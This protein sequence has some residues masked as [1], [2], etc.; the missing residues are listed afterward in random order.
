MFTPASDTWTTVMRTTTTERNVWTQHQNVLTRT[1]KGL[2]KYFTICAPS[3][4]ESFFGDNLVDS[5]STW[6]CHFHLLPPSQAFCKFIMSALATS[7]SLPFPAQPIMSAVIPSLCFS[8]ANYERSYKLTSL[9]FPQPIPVDSLVV[10]DLPDGDVRMGG[11]FKTA[12]SRLATGK[13]CV[14]LKVQRV[15]E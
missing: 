11:S 14:S 15:N 7:L 5:Q 2:G 3:S 1:S 10:E 4:L 9:S 12:I 8:S 6:R 13:P